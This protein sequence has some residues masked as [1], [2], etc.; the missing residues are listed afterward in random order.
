MI[1]LIKNLFGDSKKRKRFIKFGVVGFSGFVVNFLALELFHS[2]GVGGF[3]AGLFTYISDSSFFSLL[4]ESS[5]WSAA[6]A[7]E[8]AIISNYT[9]NNIWTFK[10]HKISKVSKIICKFFQF[11]LTSAGAVVIQFVVI[12]LGTMLF[13][14]TVLIRLL[15]LVIAVAFFIVPY[16]WFMYNAVIWKTK[17]EGEKP[18]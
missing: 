11:N 4:K 10:E 7:T 5:A 8:I 13:G 15:F 9:F 12:G 6:L 2:L 17:K 18:H 3:F 16:N 1:V 14:D